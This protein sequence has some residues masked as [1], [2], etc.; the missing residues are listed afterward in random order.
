MSRA[1]PGHS[2]R[3]RGVFQAWGGHG[4]GRFE[5]LLDRSWALLRLLGVLLDLL[6]S[7]SGV[8]GACL[9]TILGDKSVERRTKQIPSKIIVKSIKITTKS[10]KF[11]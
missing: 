2:Q 6:G 8:V 11:V 7:I 1:A 3:G 4:G 5:Y 10:F 9:G